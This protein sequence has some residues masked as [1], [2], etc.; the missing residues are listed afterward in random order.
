MW[1]VVGRVM[2]GRTDGSE[3]LLLLLLHRACC[4]FWGKARVVGLADEATGKRG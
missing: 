3:L 1:S 4:V 2:D